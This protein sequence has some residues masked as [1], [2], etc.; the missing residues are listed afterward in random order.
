MMWFSPPSFTVLVFFIFSFEED[1]WIFLL[2]NMLDAWDEF[3]P[4]LWFFIFSLLFFQFLAPLELLRWGFGWRVLERLWNNH[5]TT[6]FQFCPYRQVYRFSHCY[7]L[8][9]E[10]G[11]Q[12]EGASALGGGWQQQRWLRPRVWH[13]IVSFPKSLRAA[14]LCC[15][16]G[17]VD[18]DVFLEPGVASVGGG[19][20]IFYYCLLMAGRFQMERYRK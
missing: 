19:R 7:E 15:D 6:D 4:V 8:Q 17:V 13:G 12:R 16:S 11:A 2:E 3:W 1:G 9:G 5:L 20:E 10:W 18:N 14:R